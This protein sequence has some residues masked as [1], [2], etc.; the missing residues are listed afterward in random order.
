MP[1]AR[2]RSTSSTP[3]RRAISAGPHPAARLCAR[4]GMASCPCP[5]MAATNGRASSRRTCCP[6]SYNPEEGFFATANEYNLPAGYPAEERKVAFEWTDPSRVTRIKEVLAADQQGQPAQLD[7]AADGRR[8]ARRRAASSTLMSDVP[9]GTIN[10]NVD[11]AI[12]LLTSWDG[13]ESVDSPAAA[14]YE[15]WANKHLGKAVVAKCHARRRARARRQRSSRS[16]PHLSRK[17]RHAPRA[18]SA[19]GAQRNH[20]RKPQGRDGRT[21]RPPRARSAQLGMGPPPR[22]QMGACDRRARRSR[23]CAPR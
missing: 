19:R 1:G 3:I 13:H 21:R 5:A 2:R 9:G 23:S 22:R 18:Q 11:H 10:I 4:T 16:D 12:K 6:P 20:P 17:S 8:P 15:V 7:E 14:I